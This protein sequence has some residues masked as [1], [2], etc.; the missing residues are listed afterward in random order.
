MMRKNTTKL[1]SDLRALMRQ[2]P[3]NGGS[4]SAYIIPTDDPHQ[5][6]YI[7]E[8]DERRSFITGFDGSAGTAIVTQKQGKIFFNWLE[9]VKC[10]WFTTNQMHTYV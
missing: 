4:V 6:E 5:S 9:F 8:T 10:K 3:N 2:L 1:L 7:S